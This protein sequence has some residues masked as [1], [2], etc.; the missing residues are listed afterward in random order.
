[1][2]RTTAESTLAVRGD[3]G[4]VTADAGFHPPPSVF[5]NVWCILFCATMPFALFNSSQTRDVGIAGS[6]RLL[7]ASGR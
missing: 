1:M 7:I 6:S 2:Y 4:D 3:V 5:V